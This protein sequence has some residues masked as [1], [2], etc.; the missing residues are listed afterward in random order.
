MGVTATIR[1]N[2]SLA[3]GFATDHVRR[4]SNSET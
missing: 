2:L 4:R 3:T 1:A